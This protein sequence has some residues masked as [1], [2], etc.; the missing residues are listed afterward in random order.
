MYA[1]SIYFKN[2]KNFAKAQN[3]ENIEAKINEYMELI[4]SKFDRLKIFYK[5]NS[6][7][8]KE[9]EEVEKIYN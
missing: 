5:T 1:C 9:I 8:I 7:I 4:N 2:I 6:E 3:N